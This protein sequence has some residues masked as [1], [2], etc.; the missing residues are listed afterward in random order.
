MTTFVVE[1]RP[2]GQGSYHIALVPGVE[3]LDTSQFSDI[4]G[5]WVCDSLQEATVTI[6]E[7]QKLRGRKNH[8]VL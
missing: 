4:L 1:H 6:S 3:D 5:I 8:E 7:L 2:Q